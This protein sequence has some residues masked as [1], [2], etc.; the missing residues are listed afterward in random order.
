MNSLLTLLRLMLHT[1]RSALARG[2]ALALVVLLMGVA[3]LG[4]SGWFITAAAAA[5][6]VGAGAMFDVFRPSAMVRFLALGR[7]AARY[8]ER[9]LAHDAVLRGLERLRLAVLGGMLRASPD[10]MARLRGAQ[11]LNRITADIDALDGLLLRLV[12]PLAAGASA[13][14]IS[15][16]VLWW[17]VDARVGLWVGGG[18]LMGGAVVLWR[19]GQ[20]APAPSRRIEAAGQAF[21]SRL[22]D[23]IQSR[24]DLAIHGLL[25]R[26]QA[27]VL[28]AETR[29]RDQRRILD[30]LDRRAGVALSALSTVI[31]GGALW[32]GLDL[33]Q[34]GQITP[35]KAALGFFAALALFEAAAPL[36]RALADFGRMS[37]AARRIA[38][39]VTGRPVGHSMAVPAP[40]AA[41]LQARSVALTRPGSALP[42]IAGFDLT[43][44]PGE[45]VALTGT[46]GAGKS[47]ILLALAG[48]HPLAGGMVRLDGHRLADWPEDALRDRLVLVPQRSELMTGTI[49]EGLRL[50]A[51]GASDAELW[52]VLEAVQLAETLRP[53]GG[54]D[55]RL[56]ARGDGLS[57]GEKRR[58]VLARALLRNPG[59]LLLDEPTEGLDDITSRAVL[60]GI[61]RHLPQAAIL[62]ASHR[63]AET[64]ACD[65]VMAL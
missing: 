63:G 9:L 36:R 32:M 18:W 56:G 61:R 14:A 44:L 26:Q 10:R 62:M 25:A 60:A 30:R 5:G 37:D 39:E 6:L 45:S 54:L 43:L 23:L 42:L 59:F 50:A 47:T 31:A 7:T 35:A 19:M 28:Q 24:D 52:Q 29:R 46:S 34:A 2:A 41:G 3:L 16:A 27:S 21:R 57:G 48:L 33:A 15:T 49:A 58:L 17:L 20:R 65:R 53:R 1:E 4:L 51:P 55:L 11:A 22:I 13:V 38:P 64:A 40:G 12:L 8:G